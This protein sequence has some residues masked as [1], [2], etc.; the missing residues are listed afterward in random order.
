MYVGR[1]ISRCVAVGLFCVCGLSAFGQV[2]P[3]PNPSSVEQQ[4]ADAYAQNRFDDAARLYRQALKARPGWAE[5][6]GYLASSLYSL[7]RYAEARDAYRQT[8]VLTPKNGPSW[9]YMGFCEYEL[10]DYRNA[11]DHLMKAKQLGV[12]NDVTLFSR[13]H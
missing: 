9:A 4:A 3:N 10:R 2:A 7:N 6:W 12:G 11:F 1:S 13:L 5:G 8:A